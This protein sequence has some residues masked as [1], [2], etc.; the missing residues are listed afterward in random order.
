LWFFSL[1]STVAAQ[2]EPV[3]GLHGNTPRT[4][5]LI[6]ARIV[7]GPGAVLERATLLVRDDCIEQVGVQVDVPPDAV[8]RDLGGKTIY[9]AFIDLHTDYGMP[10]PA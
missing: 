9:P 3:T 4:S 10:A 6:H 8:V 1:V 2:T 7:T 5:A